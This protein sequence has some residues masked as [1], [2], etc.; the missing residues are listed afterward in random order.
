MSDTI[1]NPDQRVYPTAQGR[2]AK[3]ALLCAGAAGSSLA[4]ACVN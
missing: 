2:P 3:V 4:Y 1:T